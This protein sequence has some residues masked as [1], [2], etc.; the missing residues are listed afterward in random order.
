MWGK[1][2]NIFRLNQYTLVIQNY[3]LKHRNEYF[4]KLKLA[5]P[6]LLCQLTQVANMSDKMAADALLSKT[7]VPYLGP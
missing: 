5:G 7:I 2:W 6:P 3:C 4:P 1:T